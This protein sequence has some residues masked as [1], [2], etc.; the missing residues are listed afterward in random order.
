MEA[1]L[2]AATPVNDNAMR[3]LAVAR[4]VAVK[5]H[6]AGQQVPE[7]RLFIGAPVLKA[8]DQT[9]APRVELQIAPR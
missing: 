5:E 9:W 7:D 4:A 2:L 1:L 8:P 3:E 6:L